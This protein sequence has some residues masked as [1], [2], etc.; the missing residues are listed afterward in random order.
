MLSSYAGANAGLTFVAGVASYYV[1]GRV[2]PRVLI[3]LAGREGRIAFDTAAFFNLDIE[4]L[5][6][7]V[8]PTMLGAFIVMIAGNVDKEL[9]K[10]QAKKAAAASKRWAG[11]MTIE[12][13]FESKFGVRA[14]LKL[15]EG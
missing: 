12:L 8:V 4:L 9:Q 15:V 11:G 10:A 3:S 2:L 7:A 1:T 13:K 5:S 6:G 14:H